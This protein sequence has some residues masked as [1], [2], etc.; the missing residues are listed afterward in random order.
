MSLTIGDLIEQNG[1]TVMK[2]WISKWKR[3]YSGLQ[4]LEKV[5]HVNQFHVSDRGTFAYAHVQKIERRI[6]VK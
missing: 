2:L 5:M 3:I 1:A 4:I 6:Y